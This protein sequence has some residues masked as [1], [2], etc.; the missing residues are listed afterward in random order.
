MYNY[1]PIS[2][3]TNLNVYL[4]ICFQVQLNMV[5]HKYFQFFFSFGKTVKGGYAFYVLFNWL[6]FVVLCYWSNILVLHSFHIFMISNNR[7]V[8]YNRKSENIFILNFEDYSWRKETDIT[9]DWRKLG[10]F[11][12]KIKYVLQKSRAVSKKKNRS[13]SNNLMFLAEN[14]FQNQ[15]THFLLWKW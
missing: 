7:A 12:E 5:F 4:G 11:L 3:L 1:S 2:K 15:G 8:F 6:P 14:H 13:S 10:I 9:R